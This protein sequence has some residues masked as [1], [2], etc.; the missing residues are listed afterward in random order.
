M[1]FSDWISFDV[2]MAA[3]KWFQPMGV[4]KP[5]KHF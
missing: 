2:E 5:K 1:G 4:K 3:L